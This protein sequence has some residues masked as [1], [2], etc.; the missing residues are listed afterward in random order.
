M[1]RRKYGAHAPSFRYTWVLELTQRLRPHYHVLFWLPRGIKL[2]KPDDAG[3][4]THGSTRIEWAR[5][6]V[7]YIVKYASKFCAEMA[8]HLPRGYR[9]HAVGG[10]NEESK[11]ELRWWKSPLDAREALGLFADIRKIVG[12]YADKHTGLFW[13]SPWRVLVQPDG[14]LIAWKPA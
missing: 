1:A 10:L 2:P 7:G 11:R 9:T 12:G 8:M 6:A 5:H 3:W 14:R 4:W 13:P